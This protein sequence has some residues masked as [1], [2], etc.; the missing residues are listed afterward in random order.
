[1]EEQP[2]CISTAKATA[3]AVQEPKRRQ[4]SRDHLDFWRKRIFNPRY[5][6]DS[7]KRTSPNFAVQIQC[8]GE[9]RTIALGTSNRDLAAR[10]AQKLYI[11]VRAIGWEKAT[12]ELLP[13]K[14]KKNSDLAVGEFL[15]QI[16]KTVDIERRTIATYEGALR[17]ILADAFDIDPEGKYAA[18]IEGQK[19]WRERVHSIRLADVTPER[20]QAW[21]R[22]YLARAQEDPLA[23]RSAKVSVN[24]Y[25][26]R[27]KTLFSQKFTRH[28]DASLL[29]ARSPF[30]EVS[31]EK[32]QNVRYRSGFDVFKL[33]DQARSEL[34]IAAPEQFKILLLALTSGLRAHEI[35][36]LEWSAFDFTAGTLTIAPTRF[37][38]PKTEYSLGVIDLEPELVEV[39]RGLRARARSDFV[40]VSTLPPRANIRYDYYRCRPHFDELYRWLRAHGVATRKPLHTLR[41]EYGSQVC[42][43]HGIYA[44]SRALRHSGVAVTAAHYLDKKSRVTS[45]LGAALATNIIELEIAAPQ[46]AN[47]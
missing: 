32:K 38:Q 1:M 22:R 2:K 47:A 4:L 28:L 13:E 11:S 6:R 31:F 3:Q 17:T 42:D 8:H 43:R 21:K 16:E 40:I 36:V 37:F 39:W 9:R 46:S 35:D 33:L 41:K 34:A 25:M 12:Q 7:Q 45:G 24:S 10:Q 23:L 26:R 5:T 44:A 15:D 27:A 20:I 30:S 29:P 19:A 14:A 18:Q